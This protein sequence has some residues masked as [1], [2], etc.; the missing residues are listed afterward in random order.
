MQKEEV[1]PTAEE[2]EV[3]TQTK[4]SK[5]PFL[6]HKNAQDLALWELLQIKEKESLICFLILKIFKFIQ[7][8]VINGRCDI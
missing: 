4:I 3:I 6:T 8:L 1:F 2:V 7:P 5:Y